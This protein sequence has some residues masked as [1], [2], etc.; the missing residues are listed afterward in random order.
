[1]SQILNIL[2]KLFLGPFPFLQVQFFSVQHIL[3]LD[4]P[5][6]T[7]LQLLQVLEQLVVDDLLPHLYQLL[8]D[9]L[10]LIEV[11]VHN[12]NLIVPVL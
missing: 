2:S 6:L 4:D 9:P 3:I 7:L 12:S 1:M 10:L 11:L 8:L 5:D